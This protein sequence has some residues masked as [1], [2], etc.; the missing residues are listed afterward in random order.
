M[1]GGLRRLIADARARRRA[2]ADGRANRERGTHCFYCGVRFSDEPDRDRT[3]D[4]RVP[5]SRGG[6][7]NLINMVF[8]CRAC[9]ERKADRD[10]AVFVESEWLTQRRAQMRERR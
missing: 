2:D 8:A 10:E 5:R 4:H 9:N 6:P 3:I 7:N 1:A